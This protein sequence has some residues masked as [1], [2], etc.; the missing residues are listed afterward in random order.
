MRLNSAPRTQIVDAI[1]A[2][3]VDGT[4]NPNTS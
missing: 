2:S 1:M 4:I 3:L